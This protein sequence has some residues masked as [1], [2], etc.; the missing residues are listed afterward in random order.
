[1]AEGGYMYEH[2]WEEGDVLFWDNMACL[3]R[4]MGGFF[5]EPRLLF[6]V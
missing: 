3:H 6:R 5:D 2:E 4:S 1:M